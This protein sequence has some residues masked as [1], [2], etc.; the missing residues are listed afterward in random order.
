MQL[1][2][3]FC[4][5]VIPPAQGSLGTTYDRPSKRKNYAFACFS[6][7]NPL[8]FVFGSL[9]SGAAAT[10]FNWRASFW[11]LA[12]IYL[13]F[14]ILA[15]FTVPADT[16]EKLSL[17]KETMKRFDF[18]GA[19]LTIAS[20]GMFTCALSQGG[21]A[22]QGWKMPYVLV[23]LILGL[24]LLAVFILWELKYPYPLMPMWI[25]KDR[26]LTILTII[27]STN[28]GVFAATLFWITLY[29]QDFWTGSS[30]HVAAYI[31]PSAISGILANIVA[32]AFLHKI[33]GRWM[34]GIACSTYTIAFVL[35]GCNRMQNGY[36]PFVFPALAIITWATDLEFNVVNM[37]IL[38]KLPQE[39]QGIA[40]GIFQMVT[41]V[42]VT[43]V[44]GLTTAIF[45]AV[46]VPRTGFYGGDV[47]VK[48]AATYWFGTAVCVASVALIP[49]LKVG[50]QG[51]EVVEEGERQGEKN[52]S[53]K[54]SSRAEDQVSTDKG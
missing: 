38:T 19:I 3:L 15:C 6:A 7:G 49:L 46:D 37:Y 32:G 47:S 1:L 45:N 31:L 22:P 50:T 39:Q 52:G 40:G 53:E 41:R 23:L 26:D 12:I 35:L 2:G 43:V 51:N 30:L 34:M 21:V 54:E 14:S 27:I 10:I 20:I 4:A 48:Y 36:W 44:L 13:V 8:G 18:I 11:L 9:C 28:Q 16:T 29:M 17:N 24:A 25:W 5:S 42:G 33:P